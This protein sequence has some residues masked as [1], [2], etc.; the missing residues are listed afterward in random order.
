MIAEVPTKLGPHLTRPLT[1]VFLAATRLQLLTGKSGAFGESSASRIL[2]ELKGS[3]RLPMILQT[4]I[5]NPHE[6]LLLNPELVSILYTV[7]PYTHF[8]PRQ[9]PLF[10]TSNVPPPTTILNFDKR[11]SQTA[12]HPFNHPIFSLVRSKCQTGLAKPS[13]S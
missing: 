2:F 9:L 4:N 5:I 10:T 11:P 12:F 8:S 6:I 7:T 1:S 13:S 3:I